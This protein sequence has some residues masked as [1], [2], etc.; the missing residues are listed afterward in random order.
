MPSGKIAVEVDDGVYHAQRNVA[1]EAWA[2]EWLGSLERN[3]VPLDERA[4]RK[5]DTGEHTPDDVAGSSSFRSLADRVRVPQRLDSKPLSL[6][7]IVTMVEPDELALAMMALSS[8]VNARR[9]A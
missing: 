6:R 1:F 3:P 2:H 5:S 4:E 9:R 8:P 7:L